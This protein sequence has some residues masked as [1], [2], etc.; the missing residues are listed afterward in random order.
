MVDGERLEHGEEEAKHQADG[1][2]EAEH[3]E[4]HRER[5]G[6]QPAD[7]QAAV[8]REGVAA[9]LTRQLHTPFYQVR[10]AAPRAER[11]PD[12]QR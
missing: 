2:D 10:G 6:H 4:P 3:R 7:Q 11:P 9:F 12:D 1:A 5:H 8:Q